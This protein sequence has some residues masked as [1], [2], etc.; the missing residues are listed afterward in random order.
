MISY[1][2]TVCT[3]LWLLLFF[4][5]PLAYRDRQY[6]DAS[7]RG[8]YFYRTHVLLPSFAKHAFCRALRG[9]MR[10]CIVFPIR[11]FVLIFLH[12]IPYFR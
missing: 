4:N 8:P 2:Q 10:F 5:L 7:N 3:E 12:L 11:H 9:K 6:L 1:F